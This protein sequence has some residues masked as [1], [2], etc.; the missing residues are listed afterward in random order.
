M[1]MSVWL[2]Y[3]H[4]ILECSIM[5]FSTFISIFRC[6]SLMFY[7]IFKRIYLDALN[8]SQ[9]Q[10]YL[11][12][13]SESTYTCYPAFVCLRFRLWAALPYHPPVSLLSF[14]S[15]F[16]NRDIRNPCSLS[17]IFSRLIN[18]VFDIFLKFILSLKVYSI[19]PAL[20]VFIPVTSLQA[21]L[22]GYTLHPFD[23]TALT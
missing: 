19:F 18:V 7:L 13:L 23:C 12:Q 1:M 11:D 14:H 4:E 6:L 16:H 15:D 2:T 10:Y 5:C 20:W 9:R 22:I 21:F 17:R 8:N 3:L